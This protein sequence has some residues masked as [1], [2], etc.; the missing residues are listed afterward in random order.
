MCLHVCVCMSR[1]LYDLL[2]L[3]LSLH[4]LQSHIVISV[5]S[6]NTYSLV[7]LVAVF[8]PRLLEL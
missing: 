6:Y 5:L 4:V 2:L 8:R 7:H 1:T 3:P